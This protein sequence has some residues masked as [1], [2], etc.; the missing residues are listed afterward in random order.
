MDVE[1]KKRMEL[2]N[3]E[4]VWEPV[5]TEHLVQDEYIDMRVMSYRMPD[6]SISGPYYNYSRRNYAVIVA[7][8]EEGNYICVRQYRHGIRQVTTEFPAGGL[9]REDGVEYGAAGAADGVDRVTEH[10]ATEGALEAAKRELQEETGYIS[11]EWEH[12]ITIPSNASVADNWA[13]IFRA[14]NC[15]KVSGQNLDDTEFLNVMKF[16]PEEIQEMI[17][18][19][20]FQQAMHVMAWYMSK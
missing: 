14:K 13:F 7:T 11:D 20:D 10:P 2:E 8:D 16:T 4:L 15:R 6:G 19:G 9:E 17:H 5:E 3:R 12:L 1:K 18:S